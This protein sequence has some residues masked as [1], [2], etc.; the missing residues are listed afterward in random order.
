[1]WTRIAWYRLMASD[2]PGLFGAYESAAAALESA[3]EMHGRARLAAD[4]AMAR[5]IWGRN[6]E[7]LAQAERAL[8]LADAEGDLGARGLALNARGCVRSSSGDSEDALRDHEQALD[9]AHRYGT[10]QDVCRAT[11]NLA[12]TLGRAGRDEEALAL[13]QVGISESTSQGLVLPYAALSR[14]TAADALFALGRWDGAVSQVEAVLVL[15]DVGEAARMAKG[16]GARIAV[17]RGDPDLARR[18]LSEVPRQGRE[19]DEPQLVAPAWL[20]LAELCAWSD[21]FEEGSAAVA[22]GL[23]LVVGMDPWLTAELCALGIGSR[24]TV[25]SRLIGGGRVARRRH[26]KSEPESSGCMPVISV[27]GMV[28]SGHGSP[29]RTLSSY[30]VWVAAQIL[31]SRRNGLRSATAGGHSATRIRRRTRTSAWR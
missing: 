13:L 6:E 28:Q 4:H 27:L 12:V 1:V 5:A 18:L 7:A 19:R 20:A 3:P 30:A 2:G 23:D 17:A 14:S 25:V 15:I 21:L 8:V 11:L 22:A 24:Q 10:P 26:P 16:L 31:G 29:K 9:L